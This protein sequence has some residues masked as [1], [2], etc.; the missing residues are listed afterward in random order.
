MRSTSAELITVTYSGD[1]APLYYHAMSLEKYWTGEKRW[2]I[3]VEDQAIY[4]RVINWINDHIVPQ[5]LN[6]S[7][8]IVTG[9]R[10]VAY[11]GWHRQQI[12]KLWAASES[13]ADYSFILDSKNFLIKETKFEDFFDNG[14]LKVSIFDRNVVIEPSADQI[15]SCKVLG[16]DVNSVSEM[17]PITPFIW[18]NDLV[19]ELLSKLI[20][21]NYDVLSQPVLKS[22][23][24]SLYWIY[25][26]DKEKWIETKEKLAFG[27]YG[28]FDRS[29]RMT[30]EKL[31]VEFESAEQAGANMITMH[32]FHT[33]P[34][35]ADVL[36]EFLRKKGVVGDWKIAFFRET[37][38]ENLYRLRPAAIEILHKDWNLP[39]L[40][41]FT[42]NEQ[43]IEF[44]R[45]VAYGCSHTA[46][47]ELA[48]HLFW[49]KPI[50][51]TELDK[52]KRT[53]KNPT[54]FYQKYPMTGLSEAVE[55]QNKKSWAGKVAE[56]FGVPIFNR[57]LPGSSM[58]GI[59]YSI[60]KDRYEGHIT[61]NDLILIGATSMDRWMYFE[62][63]ERLGW[64]YPAT[65][66]FGWPG[67][68][69]S[70]QFYND[71]TKYV[72]G[73]YFTFFNYFTSLRYIELLSKEYDGRVLVQFMH[74]TMKDYSNFV[75][76]NTLNRR[77]MSM[78]TDLRGFSSIVDHDLC[79]GNLVNWDST[80]HVHGFYH[81]HEE[82]HEQLAATFVDKLLN[83]E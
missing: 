16:V 25:A 60:E 2:T 52:I 34:E 77:F 24:A 64:P 82:I 51:V 21:L 29:E 43:T 26:Q 40:K 44:N 10:L 4:Q 72:A 74:H 76:D 66:I 80:D 5:M 73:D 27:Q 47:S 42:R 39:P 63:E 28:G 36:G 69:P 79:L 49:E 41:S 62:K 22:S 46:G 1:L 68:W 61:D 71:F 45:I 9:P 15:N 31:K 35:N 8:N 75:T 59:I 12:L 3:V 30:P 14:S 19:R 81:P 48:D 57:G 18:R 70:E 83:N 13:K 54:E 32:R 67:R 37:F 7:L 56:K 58:Q 55:V 78:V 50:S 33:T 65:P 23:E 53:F 20:S 11:D 17:F 38:K 6:W